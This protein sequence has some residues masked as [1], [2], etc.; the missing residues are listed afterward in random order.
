MS[1]ASSCKVERNAER[2]ELTA[3]STH[4]SVDDYL[5]S[6]WLGQDERAAEGYRSLTEWFNK[7]LLRASYDAHGRETLATQ[8]DADH[9]ILTGDDDLERGELLDVLAATG[10]DGEALR[11]DMIS[12]GTMRNHLNDCLGGEKAAPE[13][14]TDWERESV[15]IARD[16]TADRVREALGALASKGDLADG[17]SSTVEVQVQLTCGEC[18]RRVPLD[19]ALDRGYVCA[20]HH[21]DRVA[22]GGTR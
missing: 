10:I 7:R 22:S 12:W 3:P 1:T 18:P 6:R 13:A 5:L 15:R 9:A 16:R 2:Y 8:L 4:D 21:H 11:D 17:E 20:E 14:R 19:T